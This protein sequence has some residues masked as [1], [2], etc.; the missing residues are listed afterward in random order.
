MTPR[1]VICYCYWNDENWNDENVKV[2]TI[3]TS[4]KVTSKCR[5]IV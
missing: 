5:V 4:N 3:A 1:M 2:Y